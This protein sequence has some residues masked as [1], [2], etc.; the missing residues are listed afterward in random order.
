MASGVNASL[1]IMSD[2]L[3][4]WLTSVVGPPRGIFLMSDDWRVLGQEG[5]GT[6]L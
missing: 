6:E 2:V 5:R 4:P 3:V 1:A